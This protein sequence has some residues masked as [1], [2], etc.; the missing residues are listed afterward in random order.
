MNAKKIVSIILGAIVV[1]AIV[2][3][4]VNAIR[5]GNG[6]QQKGIRS[7]S[8]EKSTVNAMG[9]QNGI[10][11]Y[12]FHT[13][14]RCQSCMKA[15][16]LS[17]E[18]METFYRNELDSG[19]MKFLVINTDEPEHSHFIKDYQLFSKS[20][21][22]ALIKDGKEVKFKNLT[23]IW[24]LIYNEEGFKNYVK[25]EIDALMKEM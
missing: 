17:K 2:V 6:D 12:Y 25:S 4:I 14:R 13:T 19:K 23:E 16:R 18:A 15:E 8:L 3:I 1:A 22:I 9:I 10:I 5:G 24:Q 11:V 7:A 21:I 20:L